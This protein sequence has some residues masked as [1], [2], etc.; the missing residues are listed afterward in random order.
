MSAI[1]KPVPVFVVPRDAAM[2]RQ[3]HHSFL[4]DLG[5]VAH[6]GPPDV[7]PGSKASAGCSPPAATTDGS[8]HMLKPPN[9]SK[10]MPFR[11]VASEQAWASLK[12]GE[13]NR[14]AWPATF[15]QRCGW[16]YVGKAK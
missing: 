12:S 1:A 13:G 11:W 3:T 8:K 16:S 5:F 14:L 7:P 6:R 10:P 15:L 2:R 4:P 9:G